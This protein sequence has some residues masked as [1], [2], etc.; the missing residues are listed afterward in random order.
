MTLINNISPNFIEHEGFF[1]LE[2]EGEYFKGCRRCGGEG[3]Y[4]H[5][6][7]H[8]RCYECDNTSA[9]LGDQLPSKEAAEKWCHD[10]A[11]AKAR[12]EK[13]AEAKAKAAQDSRDARVAK[14][15][16]EEPEIFTLLKNLYDAEEEAYQTGDFSVVKRAGGFLRNMAANLFN[17]SGTEFTPNM[18]EALRRTVEAKAAKA[19]EAAAHPAPT[20]RLVVTGEVVSTKIVDGDYGTAYKI[21]VKDDQG[22]RVWVSIPKAQADEAYEAWLDQIEANGSS[23][24]DFGSGVWFVGTNDGVYTGVKGKRITFTATLEPSKDDVSFAFGSR[25]TKGSWI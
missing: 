12:R 15:Q 19:A 18:I 17:A 22:F 8:S 21:M 5:N 1:Y 6:G 9:K 2:Y 10:R 4:S 24:H 11:M 20:G 7:D 13:A 25:P 23:V 16:A 3:H 14:M